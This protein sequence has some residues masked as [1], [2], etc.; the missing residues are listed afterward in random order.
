MVVDWLETNE[1]P[2]NVEVVAISTSVEPTAANYPP[3]KWFTRENW[4]PDVL[5][6]SD[7]GELAKAF[8]LTSFPY[9][10]V[11]DASGTVVT[12]AS[13]EQDAAAFSALV[14]AA[15]G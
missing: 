15:T 14:A 4:T 7:S 12:Q 6:D 8:G 10:V 2:S 5:L 9:W 13:G 11:A 1:L 3:S